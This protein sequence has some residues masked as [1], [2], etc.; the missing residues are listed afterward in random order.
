[1]V[2]GVVGTEVNESEGRR[3]VNTLFTL[4]DTRGNALVE[5]VVV[6]A[7]R[8]EDFHSERAVG[9]LLFRDGEALEVGEGFEGVHSGEYG[10]DCA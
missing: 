10:L 8:P 2:I 7:P 6:V 9:F 1:M 5:G 3:C 4:S